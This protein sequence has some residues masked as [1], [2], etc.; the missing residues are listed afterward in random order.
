MVG[1][2][3]REVQASIVGVILYITHELFFQFQ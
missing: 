1:R 2:I 3:A